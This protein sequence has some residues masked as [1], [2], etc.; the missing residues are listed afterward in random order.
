MN[1]KMTALCD[2]VRSFFIVNFSSW[3]GLVACFFA[4]KV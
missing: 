4:Q 1:E 2:E 3:N